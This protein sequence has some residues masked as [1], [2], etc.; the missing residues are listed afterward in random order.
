MRGKVPLPIAI[1][2]AQGTYRADRHGA[3]PEPKAAIPKAPTW[4]SK[5]ARKVWRY[6]AS[7]LADVRVLTEID[8]ECLGIYVT[9]AARLAKAEAEI[10]KTAEVV[11][12]PAGFAVVNPW[13]NVALKCTETMRHYGEQLGLSPASRTR[14]KVGPKPQ[15]A[16]ASRP[17]FPEREV[18]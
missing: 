11:K 1:H 3:S 4:L 13:V 10:A 6:Y 15:P 2:R 9:A 16:V 7:R 18:G 12:S 17:R 8:R 5:E 14:I